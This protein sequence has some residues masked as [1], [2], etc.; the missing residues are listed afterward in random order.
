M[1]DSPKVTQLVRKET[2]NSDT[3]LSNSKRLHWILALTSLEWGWGLAVCLTYHSS[4]QHPSI[5]QSS[6]P[7]LSLSIL[8][9]IHSSLPPSIHSSRLNCM[10]ILHL[11]VDEDK[12][13]VYLMWPM[14]FSPTDCLPWLLASKQK[15]PPELGEKHNQDVDCGEGEERVFYRCSVELWTR[16]ASAC[17][18]SPSTVL[19]EHLSKSQ[20]Y[21]Y[22]MVLHSCTKVHTAIPSSEEASSSLREWLWHQIR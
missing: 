10:N 14:P 19:H 9:S 2:Q 4:F 18:C 15:H 5:H 7:S 17:G 8:S 3:C 6:L 22:L 13:D 11:D 20:R 12:M 16:E 21:L 1:S